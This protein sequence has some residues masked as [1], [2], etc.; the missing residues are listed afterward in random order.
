MDFNYFVHLDSDHRINC[1]FN[2]YG[3]ERSSVIIINS[4][5][6]EKASE[7]NMETN[8]R[9]SIPVSM[10]HDSGTMKLLQCVV[11]I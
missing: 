11:L 7:L 9:E 10:R 8:N 5:V 6:Q 3:R 2:C 1:L 4:Q